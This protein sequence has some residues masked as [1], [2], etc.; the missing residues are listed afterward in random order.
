[1]LE[2]DSVENTVPPATATSDSRPG[3]RAISW[4]TASIAR[5]A[6]PVWNRI[7][8]IRMNM[9]TGARANRT[10]PST[11][12]RSSWISPAPPPRNSSAPM[13][14]AEKKAIATGT[15]RN[16]GTSTMPSRKKSAQ[17]HSIAQNASGRSPRGA[18]SPASGPSERIS[19]RTA[20]M[21]NSAIPPGTT[22]IGIHSLMSKD[23]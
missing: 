23:L 17:Y 16:I 8:P 20:S 4:S 1:M 15:P 7:S 3:T 9:A 19:W 13:I 2:P 10:S 5:I 21:R 11:T 6:T 12:L 22:A 18:P 14:L